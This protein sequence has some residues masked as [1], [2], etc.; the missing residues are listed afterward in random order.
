MHHSAVDV[1]SWHT[2]GDLEL[3]MPELSFIQAPLSTG[4]SV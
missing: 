4:E 1:L 3:R 2:A